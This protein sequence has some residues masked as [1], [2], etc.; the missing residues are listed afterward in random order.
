M[1]NFFKNV[2][3]VVSEKTGDAVGGVQDTV[4]AVAEIPNG[5]LDLLDNDNKQPQQVLHVYSYNRDSKLIKEKCCIPFKNVKEDQIQLTDIRNILVGENRGAVVQDITPFSAYLQILNEK[6][7]EAAE[8]SEDNADTYRIYLLSEKIINQDLINKAILERGDKVTVDKKLL[9][10]PTTTQPE[11]TTGPTSYSQ[12]IFINPTTT[13][14]I[15]HPADMSEKQWSVVVRNNSL[16]N[17]YRVVDLGDQGGKIVERSMHSAFILKPRQFQDYQISAGSAKNSQML[18][19]PYF[20]IEDDSYIEQFE[21]NKSVS[22]AVA[23]SS[24]SQFDASLAVQGGAFGYSASASASYGEK[25]SSSSESSSS[26]DTRV[27]NITYN[28]PRVTIDFH[29]QNLDLSEDCRRDLNNVATISDVNSFKDKYGRF[30]AMRVQLGGR[31]HASEDTVA[32]SAAEKVEHAKSQRAAA[33]LSFKSPYVQAS[34]NMSRSEDQSSTSASQSSSSSKS[35]CWEA[36]GGDT[37]LCNDPPAWAYTVGSFYNWRVVKQSQVLSIEDVISSIPGYQDTKKIFTE[38]LEK[39]IQKP[40]PVPNKKSAVGIKLVSKK[41]SKYVTV[42]GPTTGEEVSKYITDLAS[43]TPTTSSRKEFVSNLAAELTGAS[44]LQYE[45]ENESGNQSFYINVN[46]DNE[47][48]NDEDKYYKLFYDYPY[49]IYTLD[50]SGNK[51]YL[52]KNNTKMGFMESS[53]IWAAEEYSV[54]AFKFLKTHKPGHAQG[55]GNVIEH[56]DIVLVQLLDED[57]NIWGIATRLDKL[58]DKLGDAWDVSLLESLAPA[59]ERQLQVLYQW[60]L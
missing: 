40:V 12:N 8:T 23:T 24:L 47:I 48:E 17:P 41:D 14:S 57:Y 21:E 53:L 2:A 42:G 31:L 20:R 16:L 15:V 58:G 29:H 5:V 28:F 6:S 4:T 59:K 34:A 27:M 50:E 30:F 19:I 1:A 35:M 7:S 33:A 10:L 37:L 25:N 3:G 43:N 13:F 11:P 38:I 49:K 18:R 39:D 60:E 26:E 9:E 32:T 54:S 51:Q 36:K 55:H 56:Q 45:V 44:P 52:F 46:V 22:R